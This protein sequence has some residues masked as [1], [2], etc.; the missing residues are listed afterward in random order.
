MWPE[1]DLSRSDPS[2]ALQSPAVGGGCCSKRLHVHR[3]VQSHLGHEVDPA[4]GSIINSVQLL[5][6]DTGIGQ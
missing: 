2:L 3:W 6:Q 4:T 1:G 5:E